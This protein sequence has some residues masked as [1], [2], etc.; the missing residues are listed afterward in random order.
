M[1][2]L[3]DRYH[4]VTNVYEGWENTTIC[5]HKR[6]NKQFSVGSFSCRLD[7]HVFIH[8][9]NFAEYLSAFRILAKHLSTFRILLGIYSLLLR[10]E[11]EERINRINS[12]TQLA[13]PFFKGQSLFCLFAVTHC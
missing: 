9:F 2:Q 4:L 13:G 1:L 12:E 10:R 8:S 5:C 6:Q 3:K 7:N 11:T